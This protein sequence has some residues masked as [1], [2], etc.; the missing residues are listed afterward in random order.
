MLQTGGILVAVGFFLMTEAFFHET[1]SRDECDCRKELQLFTQTF[2]R[3]R[4]ITGLFL[5]LLGM[6]L[7]LTT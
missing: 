1:Y 5:L 6:G 3:L 7:V 4:A 2:R